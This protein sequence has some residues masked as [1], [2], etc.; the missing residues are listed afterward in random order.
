MKNF[1]SRI[2]TSVFAVAAFSLLGCGSGNNSP[3]G[4]GS[5]AG[6]VTASGGVSA[7][8]AASTSATSSGGATSQGGTP[9]TG[10]QTQSPGGSAVQGGV[11][12]GGND[13]GGSEAGGSDTGGSVI[14]G[15]ATGGEVNTGG[16]STGGKTSATGG[17]TGATGGSTAAGGT[18]NATGGTPTGGMTTTGSV[19]L[20]GGSGSSDGKTPITVWM[21]GDSTMQGDTIDTT[22]CSSCPC[23]WGDSVRFTV[24]KSNVKVIRPS[25]VVRDVAFKPWLYEG[26][27]SSTGGRQRRVHPDRHDLLGQ[28]ERHARC[29]HGHEDGRLP[30]S[31]SLASTTAA[32]AA[33]PRHVGIDPLRRPTSPPWPRR[34]VTEARKPIFLTSTN[35]PSP[36]PAAR[37]R[38]IRVVITRPQTKAAG[39][40]DNVPVIDVTTLTAALYT[41]AW[42]LPEQCND[43]T[44]TTSKVGLFFC[45]DHTHFEKAGALQI[46]Q[47]VAKALKDQGIGLGAYVLN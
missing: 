41:S 23:G 44:S 30:A 11:A 24:F 1:P 4:G 13:T 9:E 36:A 25:A 46:C 12:T 18:T 31:S 8:G 2:F 6:A 45:G 21:S 20:G 5:Q 14:G 19:P 43:Y 10:G 38:P 15:S 39:T 16:E 32:T 22:A 42:P 17:K 35:A 7:G 29:E 28:L 3:S 34:P 37:P 47:I 27:V 40:A 26:N 33:S